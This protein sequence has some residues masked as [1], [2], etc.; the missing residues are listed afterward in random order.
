[1]ETVLSPTDEMAQSTVYLQTILGI[2]L[3]K[4]SGALRSEVDYHSSAHTVTFSAEQYKRFYVKLRRRKKR[5]MDASK[6]RPGRAR[7]PV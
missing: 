5:E 7:A 1:L 4:I 3:N 6:A 2:K